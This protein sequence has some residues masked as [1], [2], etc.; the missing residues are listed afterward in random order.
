MHVRGGQFWNI[1]YEDLEGD[2]RKVWEETKKIISEGLNI[3]EV[4][5][6]RTNNLPKQ[7]DNRV[8][9]VR[10]HARNAEDT[11]DLPDGRKYTKQCFWLNNSYIYEQLDENLK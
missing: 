9:H 3:S 11:Y 10:P 7:K 6:K 4:N 1:P 8:S 5:G 2:V